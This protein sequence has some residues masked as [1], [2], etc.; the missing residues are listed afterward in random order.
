MNPPTASDPGLET[1]SAS[2]A[3]QSLF[4]IIFTAFSVTV[5]L[6]PLG[7]TIELWDESRRA[8]NAIEMVLTGHWIVPTYNFIPDHWNTKPPLYLWIVAT[9]GRLGVPLIPALRLPSALAG[10]TSVLLV[11]HFATH[12]LKRNF[13]GIVAA[14]VLMASTL[15]FGLHTALSGDCDAL[16]C[17]LT[18]IYT[19]ACFVIIEDR[20]PYTTVAFACGSVALIGAVLTKGI[21]GA[22]LLP[23]VFLYAL[24]RRRLPVIL[25]DRRFWLA[26]GGAVGVIALY[27]L[28]RERID[29]G[30]LAAVSANELAGRFNEVKEGHQGPAWLYLTC[31][32]ARFEPGMPLLLLSWFTLRRPGLPTGLKPSQPAALARP[33]ALF[34]I[35]VAAVFLFILSISRSKTYYYCAPAIPLLNLVAG[36]GLA[37]ALVALRRHRHWSLPRMQ[38]AAFACLALL[39]TVAATF[40]LLHSSAITGGE[41]V[42]YG[43]ILETMRADVQASKSP[44]PVILLDPG[45]DNVD[46]SHYNPIAA[47]YAKDSTRR[48]MP[49]RIEFIGKDYPAGTWALSCDPQTVARLV[50]MPNMHRV[51][52]PKLVASSDD[53]VYGQ[54]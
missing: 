33:A 14:L 7:H 30:Y 37:D 39:S 54:F 8:N 28:G 50:R 31:L 38:A 40:G 9:L 1:E 48:G 4:F 12:V 10:L 2:R 29:P 21:A 47:Y 32:L 42:Q 16:L 11:Y 43:D 6:V 5:I 41:Q 45:F 44:G 52:S 19:L 25:G 35:V 26:F 46:V 24:L 23:S 13:A 36:L 3:L 27:Y 53:C 18:T 49:V 17:L 51:S 15:Y 34:A 20:T 22:L